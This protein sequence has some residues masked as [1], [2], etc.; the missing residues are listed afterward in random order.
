M[1][2]KSR[3]LNNTRASRTP[4]PSNVWS[5]RD[6]SVL[7]HLEDAQSRQSPHVVGQY[8]QR[9]ERERQVGQ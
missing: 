1:G 7:V 3:E 5:E 6:E 2:L 8:L 4:I 9:V